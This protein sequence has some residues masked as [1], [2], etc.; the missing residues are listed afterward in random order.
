MASVDAFDLKNTILLLRRGYNRPQQR[1]R[2]NE[3]ILRYYLI[4]TNCKIACRQTKSGTS[5]PAR[6][7]GKVS[8]SIPLATPLHQAVLRMD[9]DTMLRWTLLTALLFDGNPWGNSDALSIRVHEKT[10]DARERRPY[11]WA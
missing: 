1:V 10:R 4:D 8:L 7:E 11:R 9:P 5:L 6:N 2:G 3:D